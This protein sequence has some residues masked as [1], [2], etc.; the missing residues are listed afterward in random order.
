MITRAEVEK[1]GAIH[2]IT[3]AVLSLYVA[4]P[5]LPWQLSDLAVHA[6]EL[7]AAA[8]TVVGGPGNLSE[9]DRNGALEV[10]ADE[11]REWPGRTVA[12][13]ACADV[14]LLEA[15]PLPRAMPDRAVLGIRPHIRPL[16]AALQRC[17][18]HVAI[19]DEG[20]V[21]QSVIGLQACLAAVNAGAAETLVVPRDGLVA[22]Y[23]C[24][25]CG[26]LGTDTDGCPDWG[27]APLQVPDVIEEMVSRV[28]EDGG[29]VLVTSDP[30]YPI[31][32]RLHSPATGEKTASASGGTW[33]V[34]QFGMERG[35]LGRCGRDAPGG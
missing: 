28:L 4:V 1:L 21:S 27:T 22:G 31:A 10:L 30:S 19:A 8:E 26:A 5:A 35:R 20:H 9:E 23:E 32:A 6:R 2:A 13:F 17:P 18:A 24:G 7:I 3:P 33:L 12:I 15:V 11:A 25:R 29:E 14:G 16:L 34:R